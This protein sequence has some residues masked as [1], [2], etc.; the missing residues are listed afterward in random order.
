MENPC[1]SCTVPMPPDI[2]QLLNPPS[3]S[4]HHFCLVQEEIFWVKSTLAATLAQLR[5]PAWS[6]MPVTLPK[7]TKQELTG[8]QRGIFKSL[9]C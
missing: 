3:Q 4:K 6:C 8:A 5:N 2:I 7:W 1:T 9:I